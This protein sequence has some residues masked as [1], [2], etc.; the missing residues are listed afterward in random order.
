MASYEIKAA[1]SNT[2]STN[3]NSANVENLQIS[4]AHS[5]LEIA[6]AVFKERNDK[7][8]GSVEPDLTTLFGLLSTVILYS[9]LALEAFVN[10]HFY[11]TYVHSQESQKVID[12]LQKMYPDMQ[13][14]TVFK[15]FYVEYGTTPLNQLRPELKN[16]IKS[17]FNAF[18]I[19]QVYDKQPRLWQD[20]ND[21][22]KPG[23]DFIGHAVP[24]PN[25]VQE[26][27]QRILTTPA[28]KY[29]EIAIGIIEYFYDECKRTKP[30]WL[31]SNQLFRFQAFR[32]SNNEQPI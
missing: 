20:Y 9:Y 21:I 30:A 24:D 29:V 22:L 1:M 27:M 4:L 15:Q 13:F 18:G 17:L 31:Y 11:E 19:P 8:E 5:Y 12:E 7:E 32:I 25:I 6:R 26:S 10:Y 3:I 23:R 28:G 14:D 2:D 16:K